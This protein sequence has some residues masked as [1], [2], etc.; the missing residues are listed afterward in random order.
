MS[1]NRWMPVQCSSE[2]YHHGVKGMKWGVRRYQPYSDGSYGKGG[3]AIQKANRIA[4][5]GSARSY[6]RAMNKL[7][8]IRGESQSK[9]AEYTD[10]YNTL[11]DKHD[12]AKAL[13]KDKKAAKLESKAW[14]MRAKL[15]VENA[16]AEA[17]TKAWQKIGKDAVEKGYSV[18][19]TDQYKYSK[20][21]R[22]DIMISQY[23]LGLAGNVAT[24]AAVTASD[25]EFR[26]KHGTDYS[27]YAYTRTKAKVKKTKADKGAM[28][29]VRSGDPT[30]KAITTN[31]IKTDLLIGD[32]R[33]R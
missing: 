24:T 32:R 21:A 3:K 1:Y 30:L 26:A 18:K 33:R 9:R 19:L 29:N 15:E 5:R 8:T 14:K 22:R 20:K 23:F 11:V 17:A 12:W 16:N 27:P 25:K 2:L 13:G 6:A 4:E 28:V 31:T 7:S 10:K